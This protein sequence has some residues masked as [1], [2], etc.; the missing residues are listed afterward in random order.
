MLKQK[1]EAITERIMSEISEGVKD[2]MREA[3]VH[4]RAI[5]FQQIEETIIE[6]KERFSSLVTEGVLEAIGNGNRGT[7]IEC[8]CGGVLRYVSE[9]RW[10]LTS[11]NGKIEINRAY[12]YCDKCKSSKV[13]LD[14]QL[15]T[16]A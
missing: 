7:T 4:Y 15:N 5:D 13:P 1:S 9:R 11:L 6:L 12:Y 8:E 16:R 14:D 2:F 10:L 3:L